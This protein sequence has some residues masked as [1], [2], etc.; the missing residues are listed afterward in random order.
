MTTSRKAPHGEYANDRQK[1]T[2]KA[3]SE[4][5]GRPEKPIDPTVVE[6]MA[7]VGATRPE[8]VPAARDR[9]TRR[10]LMQLALRR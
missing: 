8:L 5:G 7:F 3:C 6:G 4:G 2:G 10:E 1:L 9:V